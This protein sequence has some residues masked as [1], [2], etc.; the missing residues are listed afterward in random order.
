[1]EKEGHRQQARD[2]EHV[3]ST[4]S[5]GSKTR[6]VTD[7]GSEDWESVMKICIEANLNDDEPTIDLASLLLGI[8]KRLAD[9]SPNNSALAELVHSLLV[10]S[11]RQ[12]EPGQTSLARTIIA[13]LQSSFKPLSKKASECC[14][15][16]T[17][18]ASKLPEPSASTSTSEKDPWLVPLFTYIMQQGL[19]QRWTLLALDNLVGAVPLEELP[20][21]LL[22]TLMEDMDMSENIALRASLIRHIL[23]HEWC[24]ETLGTTGTAKEFRRIVLDPIARLFDPSSGSPKQWQNVQ[25]YLYPQLMTMDGIIQGSMPE[26]ILDYLDPMW[27]EKDVAPARRA[28]FSSQDA[29][30][31]CWTAITAAAIQSR[32]M[33]IKDVDNVNLRVASEHANSNV[34]LKAFQIATQNDDLLC[35]DER[36]GA[37]I[38]RL[39]IRN[40]ELH[41]TGWAITPFLC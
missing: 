15:A 40:G 22:E 13:A 37:T 41:G 19:D 26:I 12:V 8:L 16:L 21:S 34:R 7:D 28:K 6:G 18:L 17:Q 1:M 25:R 5:S 10:P 35:G 33:G 11:L 4:K 36:I 29:G 30:L 27:D 24:Y 38:A 20:G 3:S 9:D 14:F 39:Y 2:I 31:E 32:R 23:Y